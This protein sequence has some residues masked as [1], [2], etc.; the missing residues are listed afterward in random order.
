MK[1]I[2]IYLIVVLVSFNF[3]KSF[4]SFDIKARTVILQDFLSG[5]ILYEKD[6]DRIIFPDKKSCKITVLAFILKLA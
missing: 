3:T 6:A 5:E 4:A 2:L 1:K